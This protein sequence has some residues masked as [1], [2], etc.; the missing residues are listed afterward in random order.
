[1][2]AVVKDNAYGHGAV[3]VARELEKLG[4]DM[5]GVAIT[6]EGVELRNGGIKKPILILTGIR[7][8][9]ID[10]VIEYDLIP[11]AFDDELVRALSVAAVRRN[12]RVKVH[13][14]FD[15][16]MG[17]LGVPVQG[18]RKFLERMRDFPNLVIE[19]VA[20]HFSMA[21]EEYSRAQLKAFREVVEFLQG[22]GIR[23][24]YMHVSSSAPMIDFPDSRFNLVRPGIMI[25]GSYP[26]KEYVGRIGLRSV[27]RFRTIIA[28]LKRVSAGARISY[29]GT[30][31]AERESLIACL[32]VGYGDGYNR[33]LSNRG[34]VLV[35]GKRA[36]VVGRICMDVTMV[37]VTEVEGVS[38]GDEVVLL[39]GQGGDAITAEEI[40]EKIGTISYEI[41]CMVGKRV[42]RVSMR[43][44][45]PSEAEVYVR[46]E[47]G[48]RSC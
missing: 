5:L 38:M 30:F 13:L 16:G 34:E 33:L 36:P 1:M 18:A 23:P 43:G 19:G 10:A 28:F 2:M 25:Y 29:G 9:E 17:R 42:P 11:M 14:K 6:E 15:T 7:R 26:S 22:E 31:I 47:F 12:K 21:D 45:R 3:I 46:R 39:G 37:D 32:P 8:E 48:K 44:G 20:S 35:R 4:V 27:M 40:A 24:Y 41:L